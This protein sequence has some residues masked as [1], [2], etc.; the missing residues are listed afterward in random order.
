M[1]TQSKLDLSQG[2]GQKVQLQEGGKYNW[3]F[4]VTGKVIGLFPIYILPSSLA[5]V[6]FPTLFH[7]RQK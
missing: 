1:I 4:G 6:Q 3:S 5:K 2:F 7:V